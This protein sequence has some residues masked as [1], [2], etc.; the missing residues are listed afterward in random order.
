MRP[1]LRSRVLVLSVA[2]ALVF[3]SCGASVPEKTLDS[4]AGDT[5]V[6]TTAPGSDAPATTAAPDTTA[7]DDDAPVTPA[8]GKFCDQMTKF[9]DVSEDADDDF[10]IDLLDD[11][12]SDADLAKFKAGFA[13]V[14][15]T[16]AAAAA[17]APAEIS[18]DMKLLASLYGELNEAI[19]SADSADE[20]FG[21]FF[22]L[23][24]GEFDEDRL[25]A[26][27]DNITEYVRSACGVDLD[28]D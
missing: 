11:E 4:L 26:A 28:M 2:A 16:F 14:D 13:E 12:V 17:A 23:A 24:F 25:E 8:G 10:G 21:A 6:A 1:S 20:L 5:T 19:A 3:A 7:A 18:D 9:A 15:K 27:T 22:S